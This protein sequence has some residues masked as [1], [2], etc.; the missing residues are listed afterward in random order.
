MPTGQRTPK[1]NT[2]NDRMRRIRRGFA[3]YPSPGRWKRAWAAEA[4]R[5]S[6]ASLGETRLF[7]Q[8]GQD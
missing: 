2:S 7:P 3:G 1:P 8:V 6:A 5:T 4:T